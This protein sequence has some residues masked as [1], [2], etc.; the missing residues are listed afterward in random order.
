MFVRSR[1]SLIRRAF[2]F[3]RAEQVCQADHV[4]NSCRPTAPTSAP[5]HVSCRFALFSHLSAWD[6]TVTDSRPAAEELPDARG[7]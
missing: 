5:E 7:W 3:V 6:Q 1:F 4:I 2:A